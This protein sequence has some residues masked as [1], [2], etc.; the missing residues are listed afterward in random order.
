MNKPEIKLY[1]KEISNPNWVN[2]VPEPISLFIK[3]LVETKKLNFLTDKCGEYIL[4]KDL[5]PYK[6]WKIPNSHYGFGNG[7]RYFYEINI[8]TVT[9]Y[10]DLWFDISKDFTIT[11]MDSFIYYVFHTNTKD[12]L[13]I[14]KSDSEINLEMKK[15]II[16]K[17]I[18][19][20]LLE[21]FVDA[22]YEYDKKTLHSSGSADWKYFITVTENNIMMIS[23]SVT[24]YSNGDYMELNDRFIG[25]FEKLN[26]KEYTFSMSEC[27]AG[28]D[29]FSHEL[30][31]LAKDK[32][33]IYS[34]DTSLETIKNNNCI[35]KNR[36]V[37]F[38]NPKG[39]LVLQQN[40][41]ICKDCGDLFYLFDD[42]LKFFTDKKLHIPKRCGNCRLWNK[43][44]K[45][46]E[47]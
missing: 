33:I 29:L 2:S 38:N 19:Y 39:E 9:K 1:F 30:E 24:S 14:I 46:G 37:R 13:N 43:M 47:V 26:I 28:T 35:I 44:R 40:T 12:I 22:D 17:L 21:W 42:E 34:H 18:E 32:V 20:D 25:L 16:E 15:A 27:Y 36:L 41:F 11:S 31:V 5:V 4:L 6:G 45:N 10:P 7:Y 8:D 23:D 3:Y